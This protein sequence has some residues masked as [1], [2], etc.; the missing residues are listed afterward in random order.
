MVKINKKYR[1]LEYPLRKIHTNFRVKRNYNERTKNQKQ[2]LKSSFFG[3][4]Q[5]G[6]LRA[7]EK[8]VNKI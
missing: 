2:I 1:Q 4:Q 6:L 3:H 8:L 7:N 5:I